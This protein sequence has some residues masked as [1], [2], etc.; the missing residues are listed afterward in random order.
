MTKK[1]LNQKIES[2][3]SLK[4]LLEETSNEIKSLENE[5]IS[6]MTSKNLKEEFTD[7]AKITYT[8]QSRTTLDKSKLTEILGE[9]LKPFEKVTSYNVLRIK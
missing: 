9:D 5:V 1:E 4:A 3:R 2:I 7:S 8:L 6:Y